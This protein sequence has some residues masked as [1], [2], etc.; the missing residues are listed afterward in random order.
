M[1]EGIVVHTK[2]DR[3][4][5]WCKALEREGKEGMGRVQ[6]GGSLIECNIKKP[7]CP[8]NTQVA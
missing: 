5:C 4:Y 2:N 1:E 3:E 7:R 6:D 8:Y